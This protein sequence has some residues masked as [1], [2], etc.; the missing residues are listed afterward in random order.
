MLASEPS[1]AVDPQ[2]TE[3]LRATIRRPQ[4]L[5]PKCQ[6]IVTEEEGRAKDFSC[7]KRR[8]LDSAEA[9]T[10]SMSTQLPSSENVNTLDFPR[11]QE[12]YKRLDGSAD[13]LPHHLEKLVDE[14]RTQYSLYA[15][16]GPC[17]QMLKASGT[18]ENVLGRS[19][20]F[21]HGRTGE[22]VEVRR[23]RIHAN[24]FAV[25]IDGPSLPQSCIIRPYPRATGVRG[26]SACMVWKGL[27]GVERGF[28]I[29][30]LV[31]G[32]SFT[33]TEGKGR[34]ELLDFQNRFKELT[35]DP[36]VRVATKPTMPRIARSPTDAS[37]SKEPKNAGIV[38]KV[39]RMDKSKFPALRAGQLRRG[40]GDK[41]A[42]KGPER[43]LIDLSEGVDALAGVVGTVKN[44]ELASSSVLERN[45]QQ[46]AISTKFTGSTTSFSQDTAVTRL[47]TGDLSFVPS[48]YTPKR[49]SP[50]LCFKNDSNK[51]TR[52]RPFFICDT[53]GKLFLQADVAGLVRKSDEETAL[54]LTIPGTERPLVIPNKDEESF[55]ELVAAI[56]NSQCWNESE[57]TASCRVEVRRYI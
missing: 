17:S 36:F 51:I 19:V 54:S 24:I 53:M 30:K 5:E 29:F 49:E 57:G 52:M 8:K 12:R 41:T 39:Q 4:Q 7:K 56:G 20:I 23:C 44:E 10:Q 50:L 18:E 22:P 11:E 26:I 15:K 6:I 28:L 32:Y 34:K 45:P 2:R 42:F 46:T 40:T 21:V 37:P 27:E 16:N 43:E 48:L 13:K 25:V 38:G 33:N 35:S 3:T 1:A 9:L 14:F 55:K 31:G 47:S